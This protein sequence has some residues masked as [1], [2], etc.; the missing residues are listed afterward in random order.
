[1]AFYAGLGY[2][3]S[4]EWIPGKDHEID[5]LFGGIVGELLRAHRRG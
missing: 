1:M 2:H 5:G 4:H 3:T